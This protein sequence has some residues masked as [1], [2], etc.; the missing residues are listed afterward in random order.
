MT[1]DEQNVI[2]PENTSTLNNSVWVQVLLKF[3]H[4]I[5]GLFCDQIKLMVLE[6]HKMAKGVWTCNYHI[7]M[8]F[9]PKLLHSD[10]STAL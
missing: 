8:W 9:F 1:K 10:E 5:Q 7:H 3:P 2:N 6:W 4:F